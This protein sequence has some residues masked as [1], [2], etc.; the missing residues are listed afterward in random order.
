MN[1]FDNLFGG[2]QRQEYEDF[3]N[4]YQQG[5]PSEGYSEE[6]VMQR[7]Q[8]VAS[9]VPEDVY[10]QSAEEAFARLSPQERKEFF[11]FLR[12]RAQQQQVAQDFADFNQEGVKDRYQD[13]HQLAQLTTRMRQQQPGFL[14]KLLGADGGGQGMLGNPLV[15]SAFAGIAA[16]AMR[17]IM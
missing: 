13:P 12:Q 10:Q 4:R 9:N 3:V 15:K 5:H 11:Q 16:M 8:K 6:E 17:K 14:E 1:L 7:Y 2:Q